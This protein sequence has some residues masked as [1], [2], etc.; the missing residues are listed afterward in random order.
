[1]RVLRRVSPLRVSLLYNYVVRH[2]MMG[3]YMLKKSL[4]KQEDLRTYLHSRNC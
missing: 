4:V 1:M 2:S 3:Y